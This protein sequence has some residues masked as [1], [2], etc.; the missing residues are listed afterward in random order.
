MS[1]VK[2][3]PKFTPYEIY[4]SLQ[5]E[6]SLIVRFVGPVHL[7][8]L[9]FSQKVISTHFTQRFPMKFVTSYLFESLLYAYRDFDPDFFYDS[10]IH[11]YKKPIQLKIQNGY[12]SIEFVKTLQ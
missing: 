5:S 12:F 2:N 10:S 8:I 4:K 1:S 7:S 6:K 11:P 3:V 9:P